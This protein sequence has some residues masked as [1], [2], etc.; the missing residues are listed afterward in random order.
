M[1]PKTDL[2]TT[3]QKLRQERF[4][5]IPE[6]LVTEI[7]SIEEAY[8]GDRAEAYK[9]VSQAIEMYLGTLAKD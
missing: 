9:R 3:I 5:D 2:L 1:T 7:I 6:H 8:A 4:S